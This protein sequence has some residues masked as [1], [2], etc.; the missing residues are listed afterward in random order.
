MKKI[1]KVTIG[2]AQL[3]EIVAKKCGISKGKATEILTCITDEIPSLV[4]DGSDVCLKGFFTA[5]MVERG[6]RKGCNPRT[7]EKVVIPARKIVRIRSLIK[8]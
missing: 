1:N 4:R 2:K 8:C 6:E 7:G 5:E 3:A